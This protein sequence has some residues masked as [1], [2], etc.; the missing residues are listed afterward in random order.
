M[1]KYDSDGNALWAKNAN[2]SNG[3]DGV[4]SVAIDPSGNNIY[5]VGA[6]GNDSISFGSFTLHNNG[7]D[8]IFIVKYDT[9]GNVIWAKRAGGNNSDA[10]N[11]VA[12][13]KSGNFVIKPK[14]RHA[15]DFILLTNK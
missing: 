15:E 3:Y 4:G 5:V 7:S 9:S 12:I 13:D 14:Y 11:S 10:A 2:H 6:F 8:D 1:A